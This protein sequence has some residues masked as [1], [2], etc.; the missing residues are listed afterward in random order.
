MTTTT[1]SG[2]GPAIKP[3]KL[4][5]P[6]A[7]VLY[8]A[9]GPRARVRNL[10]IGLGFGLVLIGAVVAVLLTMNSKGQLVWEKWEPFT[11]GTT[12][13]TY[14]LPGLW[15]TLRAAVVSIVLALLLGFVLGI[16]RLSD[17]RAIRW[18][19]G[20]IVEIFRA[21]PV[22]MLMLFAYAAFAQYNVFPSGQLAFFAVVLG[23]T[24]YNGS[25]IAE[26]IRSGIQSLPKGQLEA[27][28]ALGLRK[29]QAM[30]LILLPQAIA[31]MLPALISQMVVALKDT[32]LGYAIGY[33]EVVRS[34]QNIASYYRNYLPALI[35]IAIVMIA[36][37]FALSALATNI[38]RNLRQ[39]RKKKAIVTVPHAPGEPGVD[40]VELIRTEG[41]DPNHKD[42][43]IDP[44]DPA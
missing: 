19:S 23:L 39:G 36:I 11:I 27:S 7:T 20:T 2:H 38:E 3:A 29:S 41:R 4:P 34:S 21:V 43:R 22:L 31:A 44:G 37:N 17:H 42:L 28:S 12:W 33:I 10:I 14:I 40:N 13:T 6:S 18:V 25:V 9:P 26:I 24:L 8:D 1:T 16:G 32:A 15:G 35:V 30:R 5:R